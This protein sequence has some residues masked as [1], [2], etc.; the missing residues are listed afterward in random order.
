MFIVERS[1]LVTHSAQNMF[2]LVNDVQQYATFLPWCGGSE[3][4]SRTEDEVIASITIAFK[5]INKMFTTR[6]QLIGNEK[7]ILSL[8][9]GPFS[10][11][12]GVWEFTPLTANASK[13]ALCLEFDFS[14]KIVGQVIAPVFK[15]IAASMVES[16]CRRADEIY[17]QHQQNNIGNG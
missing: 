2:T 16:F 1:A 15:I 10:T 5:G 13:I 3:E 8:I 7:T 17:P 6:N 9:D 11:L 14:S 12:S 4:L